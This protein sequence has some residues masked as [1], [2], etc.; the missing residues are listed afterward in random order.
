MN[1]LMIATALLAATTATNAHAWS[2]SETSSPMD[3]SAKVT[4]VQQSNESVPSRFGRG[5]DTI[6]L[7]IRCSEN[8]TAMYFNF[9]GHHMTDHRNY[10]EVMLRVD[11]ANP[12][13]YR[14]SVSTDNEALGRWRGQGIGIIKSMFGAEQL[15]LRA[16]PYS[17]S[18]MTVTFDISGLEEEI[19]PL[20]EACH[21]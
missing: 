15:V 18:P 10:G 11:D 16:T 12:S 8:S 21:W 1:N 14:M 7:I 9:K 3:D 17:E 19:E 13:T 4:L 20:R 2:V 5:S 6:G